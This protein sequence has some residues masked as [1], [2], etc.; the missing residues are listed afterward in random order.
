VNETALVALIFGVLL[1][2]EW[3]YQLR[4]VRL[5]IIMLSLV[6]WL[7]SQPNYTAAA[8]RISVAPPEERV[9]QRYGSE[10]SEYESGVVT[11]YEAIDEA[12]EGRFG[13][14]LLVLGVL[15][16]LASSPVL[17]GVRH[18]TETPSGADS[19]KM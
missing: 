10:I 1:I 15:V 14:R 3:R 7:F 8:R 4:S 19:R 11:M 18:H 6:V 12:V 16:W 13:V 2:F 9:T 17:R 5:G